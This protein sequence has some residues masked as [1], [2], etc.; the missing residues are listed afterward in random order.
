VAQDLAEEFR[1]TLREGLRS[2]ED[3]L[4][5]VLRQLVEYDYP[6]EVVA[7]DFEVFSHTWSQGFP[8][9]AF[10]MNE[11]NSEHFVYVDGKAEYP[12]PVDPALLDVPQIITPEYDESVFERDPEFD[13]FTLDAQESFPGLP[14][15]G[16]KL[17]ASTSGCMPR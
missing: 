9:R 4:I 8:A 7:V 10:F 17:V 1:L 16:K 5:A 6:P 15:A 3:S 13:T 12:S 11:S 2:L 14:L